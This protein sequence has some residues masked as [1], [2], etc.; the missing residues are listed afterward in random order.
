MKF[1]IKNSV[2]KNVTPNYFRKAGEFMTLRRNRPRCPR[3]RILFITVI[4]S[5]AAF[6]TA[7]STSVIKQYVRPDLE[8]NRIRTIAVLPL[9]NFTSDKFADEKI[10]SKINIDLLTRNIQIIEPGEIVT[11]LK[12]LKIRSLDS[13]QSEDIVNIGNILRAD[14][15][16]T[17]SVEEFGISRGVSVSYPEVAVHLMMF[18]SD[19]G[20]I[21][22]S[23]WHT[24]GGASFGT[25]HFGMEGS[26]LDTVSA[27]VINEVFDPLFDTLKPLMAAPD[28]SEIKGEKRAA[29]YGLSGGR[30]VRM[31]E[32]QPAGHKLE[33]GAVIVRKRPSSDEKRVSGIAIEVR[34][35]APPEQPE[36]I[37]TEKPYADAEKEMIKIEAEISEETSITDLLVNP[38]RAEAPLLEAPFTLDM[39]KSTGIAPDKVETETRKEQIEDTPGDEVFKKTEVSNDLPDLSKYIAPVKGTRVSRRYNDF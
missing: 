10:R 35:A 15:V 37:I 12:R 1:I 38:V 3:Y 32:T 4:I 14:A 21:I 6:L 16:I 27:Q 23:A 2:F 25:R 20:Q 9:N 29:L 31:R 24:N 11:T 17:G 26:T 33:R 30:A 28:A 8:K 39:E 36:P 5:L 18:D 34:M 13:L 22:W 7:C 19:T